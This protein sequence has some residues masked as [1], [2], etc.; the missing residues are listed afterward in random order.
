MHGYILFNFYLLKGFK[1][2]NAIKPPKNC[3][4][5][6]GRIYS[7]FIPAKESE[8]PLDIVAAGLAKDVEEV[9]Q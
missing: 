4:I 9:N 3:A 6:N 1:A 5:R 7:G 8:K 2:K